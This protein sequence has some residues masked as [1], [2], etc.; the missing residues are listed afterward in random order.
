M[1]RTILCMVGNE[2]APVSDCD[3]DS[4]PDSFDSCEGESC[5]TSGGNF[6]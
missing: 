2:T 5:D 4:T 6:H 1:T 3:P